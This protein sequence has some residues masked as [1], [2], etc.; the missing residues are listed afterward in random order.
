VIENLI[1]VFVINIK[2][3]S[4]FLFIHFSKFAVGKSVRR[5]CS[6]RS[7]H[8]LKSIDTLHENI[9][10]TDSLSSSLDNV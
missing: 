6:G 1:C 9:K 7:L 8:Y 2:L 5:V 10:F 3:T 4:Y